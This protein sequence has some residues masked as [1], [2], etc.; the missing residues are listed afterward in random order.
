MEKFRKI[1][2]I[3]SVGVSSYYLYWR[4]GTFNPESP[5]FS[6][7]L[8]GA[9]VYGFI[10][11][12]LFFFMVWKLKE[13]KPR[14]A[15]PGFNVD[16]FIPT[17]NEDP[18]T[19]EKTIRGC[20]NM[21][22]PH[23]TY[24]LDDGNRKEIRELCERLGC[25]YISR[26]KNKNAKAGNLNNALRLTDGEL[27]AIFDADHVPEPDFLE[28][29]LGYFWDERV[30]FVQTP[31]D[32][33]NVDSYQ[34]RLVRGKLWHEQSLFFKVIMRGKDRH[35]S[36]F[37]CGSCA[38]IRR[39]ALEEIGGFAEGTVTE[40]IHTSI[41]LHA[42]GWKSVYHQETLAY[43]VAPSTIKPFKTQRERWGQGAMQV[44][45]KDNPLWVRGLTIKQRIN[46]VAS[47]STYF[48]G[49]QKLIYYLS[50]IIVLL[51]GKFPI[52]VSLGEFL[53]IF[54]PHMVLSIWAFEEMSRGYGKFILLEQYNMARFFSFMKSVL[55]FFKPGRMRFRVT[56]KKVKGMSR[57]WEVVPQF[58]IFVGSVAGISWALINLE[59]LPN[60]D[61]YL[62]NV[63]WA[64]INLGLAG[65]CLAW[66]FGKKQLRRDFRFL[67]NFPA[68]VS[69]EKTEIPS[70]IE[71]LH[72]KGCAVIAP[73]QIERGEEI[74]IRMNFQDEELKLPG[75]VL[76]CVRI[77]ELP[78]YRMG[79]IF[80]GLSE[81][82]RELI[83][84]FNFRFLLKKYMDEVDRAPETPAEKV[85]RLFSRDY[86]KRRSR[87]KKFHMPGLVL[88]G[89]GFVPY[90]TEDV[91][92]NGL[93]IL[94]Y[95]RLKRDHVTVHLGSAL[96]ERVFSG[97]V[98]WEKEVY[99]YGIRA[100][101][102]GI[103]LEN[104]P[105]GEA[106]AREPAPAL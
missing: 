91:A 45:V 32:F 88:S 59:N 38:V 26:K 71:D 77:G 49:F 57:F 72:E 37:F 31:Q 50:P 95:K 53:T 65:A 87:R 80:R 48:D 19:L 51:T 47:M 18:E 11:S 8:Y 34:H 28:K 1:L 62:A 89:N 85:L 54:I 69:G 42:K 76:Y 96:E 23:R 70:T 27:I 10:T 9:E 46:Y 29:T 17:L 84:E 5:L 15:P 33:Y 73:Q 60:R 3:L 52:S 58:L 106:G 56:D 103:R 90:T 64:A 81:V 41:K 78:L 12:L 22:Y 82:E 83:R 40:D 6:L 100:F 36:A 97:R 13:R 74:T 63:F 94:T 21:R 67:A 44:F 61:L 68:R 16:V 104:L 24:V 14:P 105:S 20:M 35:N 25:G 30:A 102:Y 2:V 66:T 101:R 92:S 86:W 93:R 39:K 43:G 98:I 99:F 75:T 55:G 79:V 4:T 7:I